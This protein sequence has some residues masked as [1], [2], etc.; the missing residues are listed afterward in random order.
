M[1]ADMERVESLLV[2]NDMEGETFFI[3]TLNSGDVN[4]WKMVTRTFDD[5]TDH[6]NGGKMV[7]ENGRIEASPGGFLC[8]DHLN[9]RTVPWIAKIR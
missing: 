3:Y 9:R 6:K 5:V 2:A 1:A 8:C 4:L 7:Q